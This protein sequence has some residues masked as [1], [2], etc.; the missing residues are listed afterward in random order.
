MITRRR[1]YISTFCWMI[2]A[3]IF[4]LAA[5]LHGPKNIEIRQW[6]K[7][8]A[9]N[10]G[11]GIGVVMESTTGEFHKGDTC[12]LMKLHDPELAQLP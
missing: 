6:S 8:F 10:E 3:F 1:H 9:V 7:P 5:A 11:G 4:G 2:L 12:Y